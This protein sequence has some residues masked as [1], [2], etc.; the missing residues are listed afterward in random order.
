MGQ[1]LEKSKER[2]RGLLSLSSPGLEPPWPQGS[3]CHCWAL[4]IASA[5]G[6]VLGDAKEQDMDQDLGYLATRLD[7]ER[8]KEFCLRHGI[9]FWGSYEVERK[10]PIPVSQ[11]GPNLAGSAGRRRERRI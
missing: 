9:Y 10:V 2:P 7:V 11:S 1:C 4:A 8:F 5:G 3:G 6:F